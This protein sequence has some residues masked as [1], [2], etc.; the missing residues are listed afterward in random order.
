MDDCFFS[1]SMILEDKEFES[2]DP[3]GWW[4]LNEAISNE[5]NQ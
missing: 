4:L 3:E 5:N 1:I 2:I